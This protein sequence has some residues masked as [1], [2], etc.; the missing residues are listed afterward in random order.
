MHSLVALF[1]MHTQFLPKAIAGISGEDQ[2][3]RMNTKANHVAWL[4]GSLVQERFEL[5]NM[6][7]GSAHKQ[8]ADELFKNH[9]GI[10]D[11]AAYPPLSEFK[12]DWDKITPVLREALCNVSDE[13]L[14]SEF[15]MEGMKM[16]NY[17][18]IT[19][20]TYREANCIGQIVLWRRLMN[21]D[22]IKYD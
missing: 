9:Q 11:N 2:H 15:D 17:D 18:L 22:P 16:S 1:D 12:K 7:G 8:S 19:F 3:N 13:K 5:A 14:D 20:M 10:Q 6:L 21:Y 4:T